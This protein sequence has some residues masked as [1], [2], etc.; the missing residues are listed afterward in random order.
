MTITY[1]SDLWTGIMVDK[2]GDIYSCCLR[3]PS[4]IGN[5][6]RQKLRDIINSPD[7]IKQRCDSLKGELDCY[8]EC[9][10]VQKDVNPPD[11]ISSTIRYEDLKRFHISFGE[12]CNIRCI[13][14]EHPSDRK[15]VV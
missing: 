10:F 14:C 1:C 15:S 13:M 7:L 3:K 5:I 12:A 8:K 11:N 2:H 9:N 6:Y 4:K